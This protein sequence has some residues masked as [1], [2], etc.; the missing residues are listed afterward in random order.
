MLVTRKD[1][2]Y[3]ESR[4][5]KMYVFDERDCSRCQPISRSKCSWKDWFDGTPCERYTTGGKSFVTVDQKKTKISTFADVRLSAGFTLAIVMLEEHNL[6][7][8]VRERSLIGETL[9]GAPENSLRAQAVFIW[10]LSKI[11]L[12]LGKRFSQ[13]R[14]K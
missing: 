4:D 6:S 7:Q 11:V 2:V 3:S 9:D 13:R 10:K 5:G 14:N 12:Y 8:E 1:P